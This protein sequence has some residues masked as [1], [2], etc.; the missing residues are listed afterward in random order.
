MN[1]DR[2]LETSPSDSDGAFQCLHYYY[3]L[4]IT[5]SSW[6]ELESI[7]AGKEVTLFFFFG[8]VNPNRFFAP[9]ICGLNMEFLGQVTMF[10]PFFW[11]CHSSRWLSRIARRKVRNTDGTAF[12]LSLLLAVK[13]FGLKC[14]WQILTFSK[15]N[16]GS[17]IKTIEI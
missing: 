9:H 13:N 7:S 11:N 2:R 3:S 4:V 16:L 17:I 5:T 1:D 6:L 12:L 15:T 14:E 8:S 10:L